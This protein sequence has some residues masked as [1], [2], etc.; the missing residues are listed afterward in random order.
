MLIQQVKMTSDET[1]LQFA[2]SCQ[3]GCAPHPEAQPRTSPG[4]LFP[5]ASPSPTGPI[6][7]N[8]YSFPDKNRSPSCRSV[9][10]LRLTLCDSMD[11]SMPGFPI[12]HYLLE[13]VQ[14]HIH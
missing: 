9:M 12:F 7:T 6:H 10:K 5:S 1:G 2:K 11:C 14:I 8:Y 3:T 4:T 13:F